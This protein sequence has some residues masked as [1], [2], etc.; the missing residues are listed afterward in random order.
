MGQEA[1]DKLFSALQPLNRSDRIESGQE[2][3]KQIPTRTY[4]NLKRFIFPALISC[5]MP[6]HWVG[7]LDFL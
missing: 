4:S 6:N 5:E 7:Q 1:P 3:A 2:K